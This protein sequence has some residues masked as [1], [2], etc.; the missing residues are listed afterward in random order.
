LNG[1]LPPAIAVSALFGR[2]TL[3]KK[4]LN[5][6]KSKIIWNFIMFFLKQT[7]APTFYN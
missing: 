1:Y 3:A 4:K 6:Q 5:M 2:M 7:L